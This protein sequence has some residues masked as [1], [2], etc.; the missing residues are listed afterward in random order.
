M[1]DYKTYS[2]HELCQLIK[3]SDYKAFD[4]LIARF[5]QPLYNSAYKRTQAP[6]ISQDLVQEVFLNVWLKRTTLE[7]E[8][9]EAYLLTAIRYRVYSYFSRNP[10]SSDFAGLFEEIT[11]PQ[12]EA[13]SRLNLSELQ[14]L[15]RAWIDTLP[16]KRR[17]IFILY[18]ERHLSTREIATELN[19]SQKTVQNQLNRSM[20]DL[21]SR[22]SGMQ[23]VLFLFL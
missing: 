10:F 7:V 9:P 18:L 4:E 12:F 21:R 2:A 13:E 15:V 17:K 8:N 23:S 6:D 3:E 19:I 1:I 20:S 5:W 14:R 22:L 16:P 11:D